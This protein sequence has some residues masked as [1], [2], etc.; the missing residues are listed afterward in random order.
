MTEWR[1]LQK[2]TNYRILKLE[3]KDSVWPN[4]LVPWVKYHDRHFVVTETKAQKVKQF[5]YETV[6]TLIRRETR[7]QVFAS[8]SNILFIKLYCL[9]Y[10][11][12]H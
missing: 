5:A 3:K 6:V 7:N 9:P 11:L 12:V 4:L 10:L 2:T 8:Q 1:K